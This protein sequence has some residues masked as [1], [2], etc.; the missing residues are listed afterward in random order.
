MKKYFAP[1]AFSLLIFFIACNS[2]GNFENTLARF[3]DANSEYILVAAHRG[4]HNG[5]P[6]NSIPALKHAIYI[7]VDIVEL[8]VKVT[9]DSVVVLMHDGKIDRTTNGTGNPEDYTLAELRKFRLKMPDGTLSNEPIPTFEEILKE[10][11]GQIMIDIDIKTSYLKPVV[12]AVKR[13]GT[14]NQ[15]FY[16][17][18]D[19]ESLQ[20]VRSLDAGSMLMPRAHSFHEADSALT[21]FNPQVIH[22]DESFYSL[23]ITHLISSKNARIWI[24]ALGDSDELI[25]KGEIDKAMNNLLANHANIIQTDEPE[26]ILKYLKSKGLHD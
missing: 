1:L 6:E 18:D 5:Y 14:Q 19:Y 16:F 4:G 10:A 23:D 12:D 26:K 24:N 13:T 25:R 11:K 7:G 20:K 9:K 3:H 21:R 22:I 8:D 17:D 15:V 2:V